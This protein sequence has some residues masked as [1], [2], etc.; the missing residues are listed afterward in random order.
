MF[1]FTLWYI[2]VTPGI[3]YFS[4]TKRSLFHAFYVPAEIVFYLSHFN[5]AGEECANMGAQLAT[6]SDGAENQF[7]R[8]LMADLVDPPGSYYGSG[9]CVIIGLNDLANEGIFRW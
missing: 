4:H 5:T 3:S 8:D 1:T 9:T 2:T 7:V 6:I